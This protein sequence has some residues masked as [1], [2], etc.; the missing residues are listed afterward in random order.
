MAQNGCRC[1]KETTTLIRLPHCAFQH[2][3]YASADLANNHS[4]AVLSYIILG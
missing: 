1:G 4:I 2:V 3:D